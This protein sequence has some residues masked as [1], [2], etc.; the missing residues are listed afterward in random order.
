[1][2]KQQNP[3]IFLSYTRFDDEYAGGELTQLRERLEQTLRFLGGRAINIFQD[4]EHIQFGQNISERIEQS[5]NEV[6]VFVPILTPSYFKSAWCRTELERFLKREQQLERNYL[7]IP[8]Y[9]QTVREL[10]Q[11]RQHPQAAGPVNDPLVQALAPRLAVD[12]RKMRTKSPDSPEVRNE[13]ERVATRIIEVLE[14]LE[15]APAPEPK[16][17]I[18]PDKL[19]QLII[20]HFNETELRNL[21]FDM[22]IRYE[23]LS[24]EGFLDK[25]RELISYC[26][27]RDR[28]GELVENC[29]TL[30]PNA[31]EKAK[32]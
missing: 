13:L 21:S 8:I 9:Y 10:E 15:K 23:Y 18:A 32:K 17:E 20:D 19:R 24:G 22:G 3:S 1:M 4:V 26:I 11:A 28:Y 16:A 31:F 29:R 6:M 27:R 14:E 30:R 7:I 25:A 5:L 2:S 12:W